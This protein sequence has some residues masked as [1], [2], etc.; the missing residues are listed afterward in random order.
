MGSN[1]GFPNLKDAENAFLMGKAEFETFQADFMDHW[2]R[3][4]AETTAFRQWASTPEPVRQQ[5]RQI[6]PEASATL[7]KLLKQA[8]K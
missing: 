6:K 2:N 1:I 3:P 7:D 5:L 8:V 4:V